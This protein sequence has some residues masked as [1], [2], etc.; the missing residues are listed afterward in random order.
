MMVKCKTLT[1]KEELGVIVKEVFYE[2]KDEECYKSVVVKVDEG[3]KDFLEKI[4]MRDGIDKQFII[5]DSSTLNNLLVVRV[6]DIKHKGDYYECELL[7]Q[8]FAE[9]YLFKELMEPEII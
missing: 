6:E 4:E 8:L 1:S 3:L 7:I 5:S 9:K 2:V